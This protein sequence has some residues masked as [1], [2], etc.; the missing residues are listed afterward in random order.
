M[1]TLFEQGVIGMGR[2]VLPQGPRMGEQRHIRC[3][4]IIHRIGHAKHLAKALNNSGRHAR[5]L[6]A[7]ML[8]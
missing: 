8:G 2:G 3:R 5:G 1:A 7:N 4:F 6:D